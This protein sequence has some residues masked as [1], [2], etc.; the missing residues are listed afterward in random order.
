[1]ERV[2]REEKDG[3]RIKRRKIGGQEWY[4]YSKERKEEEIGEE[5]MVSA[6]KEM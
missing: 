3:L 5:M 4:K 2:R 1:V 6:I